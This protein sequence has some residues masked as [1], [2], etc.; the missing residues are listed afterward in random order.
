MAL[1]LN[2]LKVADR[3]LRV[4]L[5][6]T[7]GPSRPSNPGQS[8][9]VPLNYIQAEAQA[10]LLQ[11]STFHL[12]LNQSNIQTVNAVKPH[13]KARH[14]PTKVMRTIFVEGVEPEAK[15]QVQNPVL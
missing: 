4:S 9:S 13:K 11:Y 10:R 5:A 6:K 12:M 14:D 8:L 7:A 2:G 1:S 15:E 3:E